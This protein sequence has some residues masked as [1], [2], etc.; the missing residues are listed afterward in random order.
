[1]TNFSHRSYSKKDVKRMEKIMKNR[2]AINLRQQAKKKKNRK[3]KEQK[4]QTPANAS[5][6]RDA[7]PA[8]RLSLIHI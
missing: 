6:E 3:A 7:S 2:L 8:Q 1:M 4:K 5:A